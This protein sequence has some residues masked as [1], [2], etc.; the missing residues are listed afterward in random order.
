MAKASAGEPKAVEDALDQLFSTPPREFV[1]A[2]A[3]LVAS[4]RAQG[5]PAGAKRV[6]A[7]R[8][9]PPTAWALNVVAREH[10]GVMKEYVAAAASLREAQ[11]KAI[12]AEEAA[13]FMGARRDVSEHEATVVALAKEAMARAGVAWTPEARRRLGQTLRAL[14]LADDDVRASL[15]AGRLETEIETASDFE[16]LAASLGSTSRPRAK[17]ATESHVESASDGEPSR[18]HGKK[19]KATRDDDR[20]DA[21]EKKRAAEALAAEEKERAEAR[22]RAREEEEAAKAREAHM[23]ATAKARELEG[24][25][26]DLEAKAE[27]LAGKAVAAEQEASRARATAERAERD[28][29][30]ARVEAD[31]A[32]DALKSTGG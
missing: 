17:E 4:L 26:R 1:A 28:A 5:D 6:A 14:A 20:E 15:L 25:A 12:D 29:R 11:R 21:I 23:R 8:R 24:T 13:F 19:H 27:L 9:P 10:P 2:R 31:A 22:R 30:K 16:A 7:T 32:R 3:S 18:E